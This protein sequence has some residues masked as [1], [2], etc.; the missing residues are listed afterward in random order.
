ME[1]V[2]RLS[3]YKIFGILGFITSIVSEFWSVEAGFFD[4][5]P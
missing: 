1:A 2:C 4:I 5:L 3:L